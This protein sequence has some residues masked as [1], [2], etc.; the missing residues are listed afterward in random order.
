MTILA[1]LMIAV[2]GIVFYSSLKLALLPDME[3]PAASVICTFPRASPE[4]VE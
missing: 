2:F 4:D 3:F 1:F